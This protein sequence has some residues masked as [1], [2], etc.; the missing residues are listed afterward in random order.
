[1][2][3][4]YYTS[5]F[6]EWFTGSPPQL[7]PRPSSRQGVA[8]PDKRAAT[9]TNSI[10]LSCP[11][12]FH[13]NA[14]RYAACIVCKTPL[15]NIQSDAK[16]SPESAPAGESRVTGYLPESTVRHHDSPHRHSATG[17][18]DA[19]RQEPF[20]G[21]RETQSPVKAGDGSSSVWQHPLRVHAA[22]PPSSGAAHQANFLLEDGK[23]SCEHCTISNP[24]TTNICQMCSK[25]RTVPAG[26]KQPAPESQAT[27]EKIQVRTGLFK[28]RLG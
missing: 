18:G 9:P 14:A 2:H 20:G 15:R 23:W 11:N 21:N 17:R 24:Q 1:M 3:K 25:T 5:H 28:A 7:P 22:P 26:V 8:L 12:C 4:H 27:S 16:S 6:C 13:I 10:A 19:A